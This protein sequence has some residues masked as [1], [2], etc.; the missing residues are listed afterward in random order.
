MRDMLLVVLIALVV[1][2]SATTLATAQEQSVED[3]AVAPPEE[4]RVKKSTVRVRPCE[5]YE[6]DVTGQRGKCLKY[7]PVTRRRPGAR[8]GSNRLKRGGFGPAAP[9]NWKLR[10]PRRRRVIRPPRPQPPP[11]DQ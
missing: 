1:L 3:K 8:K 6:T 5:K 10:Q 11:K 7:K 9:R 4:Q 2:M